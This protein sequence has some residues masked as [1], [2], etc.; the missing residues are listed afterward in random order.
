MN[1]RRESYYWS[2]WSFGLRFSSSDFEYSEYLAC[3]LYVYL[4]TYVGRA[5]GLL[6]HQSTFILNCLV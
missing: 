5:R 1:L 2:H 6:G 4:R 3:D